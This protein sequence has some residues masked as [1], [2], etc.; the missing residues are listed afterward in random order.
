MTRGPLASSPEEASTQKGMTS[1]SAPSDAPDKFKSPAVDARLAD[2]GAFKDG[3]SMPHTRGYDT[4][5]GQTICERLIEGKSL[6]RICRMMDMPSHST[7]MRWLQRNPDFREGYTVARELQADVLFDQVLEIADGENQKNAWIRMSARMWM[8]G[9]MHPKKYGRN[10]SRAWPEDRQEPIVIEVVSGVPR[11]RDDEP[12][13]EGV[14]QPGL[15]VQ[16]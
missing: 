3:T 11:A 13:G 6:I 8:V 12:K 4:E 2:F 9:R 5:T 10:P 15:G 14:A 16:A 7:V 1:R